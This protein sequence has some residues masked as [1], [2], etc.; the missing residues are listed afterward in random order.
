[1]DQLSAEGMILVAYDGSA[2]SDAALEWAASTAALERRRVRAVFVA[3][4]PTSADGV[5]DD[6][7]QRRVE[8][9]LAAA[10]ADGTFEELAGDVEAVLLEQSRHAHVLVA[11]TR[12]RGRT[13]GASLR[14]GVGNASP[15][16][17][18]P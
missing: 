8:A 17:R 3:E 6:D 5:V 2:H 11:G 10:R 14:S 16:W 13:A 1:M 9:V 12:G 18:F 7:L 15:P 4:G